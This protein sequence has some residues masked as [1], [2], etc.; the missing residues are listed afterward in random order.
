MQ[1]NPQCTF[2]G[3]GVT[4]TLTLN[5]GIEYHLTRFHRVCEHNHCSSHVLERLCTVQFVQ[6]LY[7]VYQVELLV[8]FQ[9]QNCILASYL[10]LIQT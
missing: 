8:L 6:G 5:Q 7:I 2:A 9:H 10:N 1:T 4:T 3:K